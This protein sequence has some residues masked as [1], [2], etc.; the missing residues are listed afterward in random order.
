MT[1][2]HRRLQYGI[3]SQHYGFPAPRHDIGSSTSVRYGSHYRSY[4]GITLRAVWWSV[5]LVTC[6][7][8]LSGGMVVH[9]AVRP[10]SVTLIN[11]PTPG[12]CSGG[13]PAWCLR[14][15]STPR[16]RLSAI[17]SITRHILKGDRILMSAIGT[18]WTVFSQSLA[19]NALYAVFYRNQVLL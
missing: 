9:F 14:P 5:A 12:G 6:V 15:S 19:P 10:R 8:S 2:F 13:R 3:I 11:V 7:L 17:V 16:P 1:G 4:L 18:L